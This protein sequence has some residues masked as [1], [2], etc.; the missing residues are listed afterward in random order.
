M[1]TISYCV[2]NDARIKSGIHGRG[3]HIVKILE[4]LLAVVALTIV[5]V[6]MLIAVA[7]VIVVV[8]EAMV[9]AVGKYYQRNFQ[10]NFTA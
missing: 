9:M 10:I 8:T 1:T 6:V 2:S 3:K 5:I 7:L 4:V